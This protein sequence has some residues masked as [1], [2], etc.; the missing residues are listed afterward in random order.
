MPTPRRNGC[1]LRSTSGAGLR[2]PTSRTSRSRAWRRNAS[3]SSGSSCSRTGSTPISRSAVTVGSSASCASSSRE[4]PLRERLRAQLMAA[5]YR[6][7]RQAEALEVYREGR[8]ALSDELGIE[9]GPALRELERA[10]LQQDPTLGAPAAPPY[11]SRSRLR[12]RWLLLAAAVVVA[13]AA[14]AAM[15]ATRG[16]SGVAAPVTVYPHSVAVIDPGDARVV[17]DVLVGGYP[18]TFAA[19]SRYVY[20]VNNGDATVS[21]IDP[22]ARKVF[23]TFGLSRAIDL[24]ALGGHLWAANGGSPGHTPLGVGPGTVLDYGPVPTLRTIRVGPARTARRSRRRLPPAARTPWRSGWEIRTAAPCARS[25]ARSTGPCGRSVGSRRVASPWSA[26]LTGETGLG[27]R[28]VAERRRPDRRERAPHCPPD[29]DTRPADETR[30]R[31]QRRLGDHE[32]TEGRALAHRPED[33]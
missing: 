14:A 21:R 22:K 24:V 3:R 19:D 18:T 29:P 1:G 30:G 26:A 13:G 15:L 25:T 33:E 23:D 5:L 16:G 20:V 8:V 2:S 6:S 27:E 32:W 12:R 11:A 31:R 7:G 28:P 9:P 4:Y 17:D 10:I